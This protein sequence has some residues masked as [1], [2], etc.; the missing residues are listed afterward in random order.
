MPAI[1]P[2][3]AVAWG[4]QL[5]IQS[6][7]T[8]F[9]QPWEATAGRDE[10]RE[11]VLAADR[12]GAHYVAVCDHIAVD[13]GSAEAMSTTWY[14]T[15]TTLGWIAALTDSVHLLSHV[16][17]LPYRHPLMVAKGFTT[18]DEL[19]DG[20]AI[21]GAGAGHL[22]TEFQMLGEDHAGRGGAMEPAITAI[23]EA[24][25]QEWVSTG[26]GEATIEV[27]ISPRPVRPGGPP[28]WLGGSSKA[29]IRRA[30]LLGD[31]W[32]PQGPP[33]MGT[34]AAMEMIRELRS[35]ADLPAQFDMGVL[36][37]PVHIGE[38]REGMDPYTMFGSP[39]E[40]AEKLA[41]LPERGMNQLQL[42]FM[43][44]SA[45]EY[46]EQVEQFGSEVAPLLPAAVTP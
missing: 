36:V 42:R 28:I 6:K 20:R 25:N 2:P 23:R 38:P 44:D 22:E 33:K 17:V 34:R 10:L 7:S 30:A 31:G 16:Y 29:A 27:G 4:M 3:G 8:S 9:V 43:G 24:F 19:S 46:A 37:G 14:D 45:G 13:R 40:I 11:I 35:D 15:L 32:L 18:L 39:S 21:L 5:P 26:A 41:K 1:I 12:G